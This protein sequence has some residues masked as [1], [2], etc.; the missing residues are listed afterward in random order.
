MRTANFQPAL[1]LIGPVP[2]P[3]GGVS[4]HVWRLAM[5]MADYGCRVLDL[6]PADKKYPTPGVMHECSPRGWLH[7]AAWLSGKLRHSQA[8]VTHVHFSPP[9][10]FSY[11]KL[12]MPRRQRGHQRALTLHHGNLQN[13]HRRMNRWARRMAAMAISS[14]DLI[15]VLSQLQH[16]YYTEVVGVPVD[17]LVRTTSFIAL[18]REAMTLSASTATSAAPC[19]IRFVAAGGFMPYYGH[20]DSIRLVDH[21]RKQC[22]ARLTLCL[23]GARHDGEYVQRLLSLA[24]ER[25]YVTLHFDLDLLDFVPILAAGDVFLR[26]NTVDSYGLAVGDAVTLG[27]P[28]VASDVCDRHPGAVLFPAGDYA[29][30]EQA[31]EDVVRNLAR[32]R[33]RIVNRPNSDSFGAHLEAYQLS[34]AKDGLPRPA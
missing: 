33:S 12:W 32:H 3:N 6:Y 17:R 31:V 2:R 30:F 22:D 24:A 15:F 34:V 27:V 5:R 13:Y 26:P 20:E 14:F 18:P 29:A 16:E 9:R 21:F 23:Y 7:K 25:P 10:A 8:A 28:S 19:D 11:G 1:D 4:Q